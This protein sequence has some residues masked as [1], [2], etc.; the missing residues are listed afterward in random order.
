MIDAY[1]IGITLALDNGVSE[2]LATIRRDLIALNGV[3]ENSAMRLAHLTRAAADLQIRPGVAEPI[4]RSSTTPA[5]GHGDESRPI[6]SGSSG[7]DIGLFALSRSALLMAGKVLTPTLSL[8]A[9]PSIADVGTMAANRPATTSSEV[10]SLAS[11]A[12]SLV[13]GVSASVPVT[14]QQLG[15]G[16]TVADFAPIYYP[17][18]I[19]SPTLPRAVPRDGSG[20]AFLN[21]GAAPPLS[22][23]VDAYARPSQSQAPDVSVSSVEEQPVPHPSPQRVAGTKVHASSGTRAI[24]YNATAWAHRPTVD[25]AL[26]STAPPPRK[27]RSTALQ[28]DIYLDGSRLGRWMTDGFVKAA[29]LPRAATTGFDPRMTPTWPGAPVDA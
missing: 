16:A 1:T 7:L 22:A 12:R 4:T 17:L 8:P 2:G 3:V 14:R 20:G 11:E 10:W 9:S 13:P 24:P 23:V 18:Q 5:G 29:Q 28:G 26:P 15:Q 27:P 21:P 25:G 19:P 6:P